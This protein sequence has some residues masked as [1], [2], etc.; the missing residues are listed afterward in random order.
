MNVDNFWFWWPKS[1]WQ[2]VVNGAAGVVAWH[3]LVSGLKSLTLLAASNKSPNPIIS[4]GR[5]QF[6]R[7]WLVKRPVRSYK[8]HFQSN[9]RPLHLNCTWVWVDHT[10]STFVFWQIAWFDI[11]LTRFTVLDQSSF[12]S[13]PQLYGLLWRCGSH[14]WQYEIKAKQ[15]NGRLCFWV[16]F[17]SPN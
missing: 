1:E 2:T 4:L 12:Y 6:L 16:A 8:T 17:V 9:R 10:S 7:C 3:C 15:L 5:R 11:R 14:N 13:D